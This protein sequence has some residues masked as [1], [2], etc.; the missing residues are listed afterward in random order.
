MDIYRK[1]PIEVKAIQLI[2][3]DESISDAIEFVDNIDMSTCMFL[4]EACIKQVKDTGCLIIKTP[5]GELKDIVSFGDY[6]IK[7]INGEI[8]SCKSNIFYKT[9]ELIDY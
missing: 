9:Y 4:R 8:S 1:K 2:N 7:D 6:I 3:D 5:E